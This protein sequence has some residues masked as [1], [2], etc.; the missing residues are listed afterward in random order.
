MGGWPFAGLVFE[1][2]IRLSVQ[3]KLKLSLSLAIGLGSWSVGYS[4]SRKLSKVK[5]HLAVLED[6][7]LKSWV[8]PPATLSIL[9][10]VI[11]IWSN[12][13][14]MSHTFLPFKVSAACC[15]TTLSPIA[16][17]PI[18]VHGTSGYV[19]TYHCWITPQ[20]GELHTLISDYY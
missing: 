3:L 9:E 1:L 14:F 17:T 4:W 19:C 11:I 7:S 6:L 16:N 13:W 5:Q 20:C 12:I 10:N 2:K 8:G 18:S 15:F